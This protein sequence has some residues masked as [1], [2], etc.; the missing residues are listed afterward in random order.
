MAAAL[1]VGRA[2]ATSPAASWPSHMCVSLAAWR[3]SW[4]MGVAPRDFLFLVSSLLKKKTNSLR[5]KRL[6]I[7][8]HERRKNMLKGDDL[9]IQVDRSSKKNCRLPMTVMID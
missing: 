1:L 6:C 3:I 7:I 9:M 5:G 4:M 2:A 8:G